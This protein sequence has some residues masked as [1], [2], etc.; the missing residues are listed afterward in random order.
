VILL[1]SIALPDGRWRISHL[2]WHPQK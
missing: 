2:M 1:L